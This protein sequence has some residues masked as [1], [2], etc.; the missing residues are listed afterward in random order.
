MATYDDLQFLKDVNG[1]LNF[2]REQARIGEKLLESQV[3]EIHRKGAV[4]MYEIAEA[5]GVSERAVQY[6]L[7]EPK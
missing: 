2:M 1:L 4:T 7:I 6:M 3:R 5:L